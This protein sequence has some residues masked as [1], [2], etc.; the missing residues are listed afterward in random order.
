MGTD[1][2]LRQGID[3][4]FR[5]GM[6]NKSDF[7][8]CIDSGAPIGVVAGSLT[9]AQVVNSLPIYLDKGGKAFIDSG[10]FTVFRTKEVM[11]W[12]KVF[13]DYETVAD[14]TDCPQNLWVVAPDSIG[15]QR[16][17]LDLLLEWRD[18]ILGLI[19]GGVNVIVP[20][21]CGAMPGQAMVERITDVLGTGQWVAGIPS[22][23][24]AM[25]IDECATL[26]HNRFHVLG[27]V[28]LDAEQVARLTALRKGNPDA[29]V[30]ADANWLRS[31]L[32]LV[33]S[34]LEPVNQGQHDGFGRHIRSRAV[35]LAIQADQA[36]GKRVSARI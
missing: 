26:R 34:F 19:R 28:Q 3:I 16:G 7:F 20:L 33:S 21:Q 15:N 32:G 29:L 4:S 17:T 5:S 27:R 11:D 23:K 18:R 12:T 24:A 35:S 14:L 8:G 1:G 30:S 25:T 10:A 22:N 2:F 6:T 13:R 9:T 31:R 36:W